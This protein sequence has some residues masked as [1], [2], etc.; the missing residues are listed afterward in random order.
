MAKSKGSGATARAM[1]VSTASKSVPASKASP[2]GGLTKSQATD[3]AEDLFAKTSWS[4]D[5]V[6]ERDGEWMVY[7]SKKAYG[8][9]YEARGEVVNGKIV[10]DEMGMGEKALEFSRKTGAKKVTIIG[11]AD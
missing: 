7:T 11:Y 8:D 6:S 1:T 10:N 9:G 5:T 3:A 4:V 2:K